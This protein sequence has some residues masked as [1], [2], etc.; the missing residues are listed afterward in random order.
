MGCRGPRM[1]YNAMSR[2]PRPRLVD[3]EQPT[4]AHCIRCCLVPFAL[5]RCIGGELGLI[6]PSELYK[7]PFSSP[8]YCC[9]PIRSR[10]FRTYLAI[11]VCRRHVKLCAETSG[12]IPR[13][14]S[15]LPFQEAP[16]SPSKGR[17][18]ADGQ[19]LVPS[20]M[21]GAELES[22][23]RAHQFPWHPAPYLVLASSQRGRKKGT[24]PRLSVFR[25][26]DH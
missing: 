26:I 4:G 9:R 8:S 23:P 20:G 2:R 15:F 1:G 3:A 12:R 21:W 24:V 22:D 19:A 17:G 7:Q 16:S 14:K 5:Y 25:H 13:S 11:L 6:D 18:Q 10:D